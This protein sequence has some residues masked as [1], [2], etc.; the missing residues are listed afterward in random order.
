[1]EFLKNEL[2]RKGERPEGI[3]GKTDWKN[4]KRLAI[5][6][7]QLIITLNVSGPNN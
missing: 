2:K 6:A 5:N 3:K 7:T 4:G 1:M